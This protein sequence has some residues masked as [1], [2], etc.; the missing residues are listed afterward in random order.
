MQIGGLMLAA[1]AALA[2]SVPTL[3]QSKITVI[4]ISFGGGAPATDIGDLLTGAEAIDYQIEVGAGQRLHV[5]MKA[6]R[7]TP[8]FNILPP[9]SDT[10]I[11]V[12]SMEGTTFDRKV[13]AAGTYTIR[14]YQMGAAR[15]EA[16]TTEFFIG[17]SLD[18]A[19][20][21]TSGGDF[22][23]GD[24]GGPDFWAVSGLKAGASLNVR[25]SPGGDVML[26]VDEGTVLRNLGCKSDTGTRWCQVESADGITIKGWVSG[27]FLREAAAPPSTGDALVAGTSFNATGD[28]PC[29]IEADPSATICPFGVKREPGG[30]ASVS[31]TLPNGFVRV[32]DFTSDGVAPM[33]GAQ[34]VTGSRD[35]DQTIVVVDA[36]AETYTIPDVVVEGD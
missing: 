10:A 11:F 19:V 9:G 13:D 7:P 27:K 12:G 36:G 20:A 6:K 24:A 14:V 21:A 5:E 29:R 4:P 3:A 34:A 32:L 26:Q 30:T 17:V 1:V 15:D 23:D 22:A 8:Y 28:L 16:K 31:I 33:S 18:G 35:G 25:S 2:L